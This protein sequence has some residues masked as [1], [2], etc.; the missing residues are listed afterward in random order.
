MKRKRAEANIKIRESVRGY[1]QEVAQLKVAL[2]KKE[3]E[4]GGVG[5]GARLCLVR[6]CVAFV[7]RVSRSLSPPS[8]ALVPSCLLCLH[9]L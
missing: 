2:Q 5:A 6:V 1:K 3:E 9:I 8:L 4:A 7:C